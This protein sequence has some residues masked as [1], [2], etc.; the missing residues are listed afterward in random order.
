MS[1][2]G[3]EGRAGA[4]V[5]QADLHEVV[6]HEDDGLEDDGGVGVRDVHHGPEVDADVEVE[7]GRPGEAVVVAVLEGGAEEVL[8]PRND[9]AERVAVAG[10]VG[11]AAH[12]VVALGERR[13]DV[14]GRD[15]VVGA[16]AGEA[17]VRDVRQLGGV[18][19][20][21][22]RPGQAAVYADET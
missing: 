13:R 21:A 1:Q 19:D 6:R 8:E 7:N 14:L 4:G 5:P 10:A 18:V 12:V 2:P 11:E 3:D 16:G 17:G 9:G 20:V 15:V 22:R